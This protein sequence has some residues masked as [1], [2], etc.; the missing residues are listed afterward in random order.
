MP[1]SAGGYEAGSQ[2]RLSAVVL[3]E[4]DFI[5]LVSP[6][7]YISKINTATGERTGS[8]VIGMPFSNSNGRDLAQSGSLRSGWIWAQALAT[9]RPCREESIDDGSESQQ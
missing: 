1:G 5:R 6:L 9:Q 2:K 3:F 8:K 7:I 4:E